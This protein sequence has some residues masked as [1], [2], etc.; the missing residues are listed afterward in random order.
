MEISFIFQIIVL[1]VS[2]MAHEVAHGATAFYFGDPTAKNQGRLT[3]NPL[4]HIDPLGSVIIPLILI[5][6]KAGFI[7]G[8]ARPVPYNPYNLKNRKLGEFCVSIAGVLT[9]FLIAIVF[10][11][12]LRLA[13]VW[14]LPGSTINL[15]AYIVLL[16][17][18][19]GVFNLLPIP[20]LD[21]SKILF[22]IVPYRYEHKLIAFERHGFYLVLIFLVFFSWII[23]DIVSFIF[24]L[25]I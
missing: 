13:L 5:L 6:T 10:A 14:D 24:K 20:P 17:I 22:S 21:G 16:N 8:W 19:L 2:V 3:L 25:L 15:I 4:K 11:F 12:I 23:T 18:T 9:N 7:F 1:I